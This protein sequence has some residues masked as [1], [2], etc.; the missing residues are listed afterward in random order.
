MEM[1][2]PLFEGVENKKVDIPEWLDHPFTPE[3]MQV[4]NRTHTV[5]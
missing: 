2:I 4:T 5:E 1:T 3:C